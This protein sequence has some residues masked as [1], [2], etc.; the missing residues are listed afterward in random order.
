M[1]CIFWV[2]AIVVIFAL[3]IRCCLALETDCPNQ[4]SVVDYLQ[5]VE[6][7]FGIDFSYSN[8]IWKDVNICSEKLSDSLAFELL[9]I[10]SELPIQLKQVDKKIYAVIPKRVN[11]KLKITDE[12]SSE[13]IP[14]AYISVNNNKK[15]LYFANGQYFDIKN[16]LP[17]DSIEVAVSFYNPK[18]LSVSSILNGRDE[19]RLEGKVHNIDE[20]IILPAY[21]S[22]GFDSRINDASV[23]INIQ[24][25]TSIAGE[26]DGDVYQALKVLPGISS[27]SGKPGS[28]IIR[29]NSYTLNL[30]QYDDIPIYHIGHLYG[31]FSPY[32]PKAISDVNV[33]RNNVPIEYGGKAGSMVNIQSRN[34]FMDS[35]E[36]GIL[37]NMVYSGVDIS[38]PVKKDKLGIML[39]ARASLPFF[40]QTPKY[41]ALSELANQGGI[42][43]PII[44]AEPGNSTDLDQNFKDANFKLR[45]TPNKKNTFSVS[46]IFIDNSTDID[47]FHASSG[48]KRNQESTYKNFGATAKWEKKW[49]RKFSSELN[50]TASQ[51]ELNDYI[52]H[53][54][55]ADTGIKKVDLNIT[56]GLLKA[57][58][59]Y[60]FNNYQKI[61]GGLSSGIKSVS[62]VKESSITTPLDSLTTGF[63]QSLFLRHEGVWGDKLI[64]S[65]GVRANYFNLTNTIRP[66]INFNLSYLLN[67][68][69]FFKTSF[70]NV[71]QYIRINL[72]KDFEDYIS[73]H[74]YWT[75]VDKKAEIIEGRQ[76]MGGLTLKKRRWLID[77]EAYY[78]TVNNMPIVQQSL[79]D[80]QS[81]KPTDTSNYQRIVKLLSQGEQDAT[82][83]VT[84][85]TKGI[86]LLVKKKWN[87]IDTWIS[88]TLSHT[89]RLNN[90]VVPV[91]YDRLH[92]INFTTIVPYR[93][94]TFSANWN[95]ASGLPVLPINFK[96]DP[97]LANEIHNPY[98]KRY[99]FT[100]QLDISV[101]CKLFQHN[102]HMD[103]V[104]GVSVLNVYNQKNIVNNY[105]N[106]ER[107]DEIYRY[108]IGFAPNVQLE[109]R[110]R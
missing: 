13:L 26:T 59:S 76:F 51:F 83:L 46:S 41:E 10:S 85:Q 58:A 80:L 52:L 50:F 15:T 39:A 98:T 78:K 91:Y 40:Q 34:D 43:S 96:G 81:V 94:W 12:K 20:V 67:N 71:Y 90:V 28:I 75:Q 8:S 7:K 72:Q 44:M 66:D 16:V 105:L 102:S 77:I 84:L 92:D 108:G 37:S 107:V 9:K 19:I 54:I 49:T 101:T 5:S 24:E 93:R 18:S 62:Y 27:P 69:L 95:L 25:L 68:S 57:S 33:Y 42:A 88:Y 79:N 36:I 103:G 21:M 29:G 23:R 60:I 106:V 73:I 74:Q 99:P 48:I 22:R 53:N 38:T 32:N 87:Q 14:L 97:A 6:K 104:L 70:S 2:V 47:V 110:F 64:S 3:N 109:V 45:Y 89:Y 55:E 35:L 4:V 82:D 63:T 17:S 11:L 65:L 56:D 61:S 100:H 86:D 30:V 31:A 1:R